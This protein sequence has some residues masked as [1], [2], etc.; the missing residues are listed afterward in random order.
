MTYSLLIIIINQSLIEDLHH[1]PVTGA[2]LSAISR[3]SPNVR[4][5]RQ[6]LNA[7]RQDM[8]THCFTNGRP[9]VDM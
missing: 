9:Q 7:K 1:Y 8:I 3:P 5:V 4:S 6:Y 2:A